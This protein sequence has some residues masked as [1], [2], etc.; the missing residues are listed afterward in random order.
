MQLTFT[1]KMVVAPVPL[2]VYLSMQDSALEAGLRSLHEVHLKRIVD[3]VSKAYYDFDTEAKRD[4]EVGGFEALLHLSN[5]MLRDQLY[6]TIHKSIASLVG[7]TDASPR[8]SSEEALLKCLDGSE[9]LA[10]GRFAVD[11]VV[12]DGKTRFSPPLEDH[13]T[14][15]LQVVRVSR[16]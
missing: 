12:V 9:E 3:A 14:G 13:V 4:M 16:Q 8:Q 1:A 11:L 6:A 2:A 7:H 15:T 5:M 10:G